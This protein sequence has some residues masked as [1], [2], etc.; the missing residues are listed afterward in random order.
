MGTLIGSE[1]MEKNIT[2]FHAKSF[3]QK[4]VLC[5]LARGDMIAAG[6]D[7]Q[8][9][10][11]ADPQY[12][13]SREGRLCQ[14]LMQAIKDDDFDSF[15]KALSDYNEITPLDSWHM[16]L[17]LKAKRRYFGNPGAENEDDLVGGGATGA[18]G[19]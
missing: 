15:T 9:G 2:K 19:E 18:G 11:N 14:S 8:N 12:P 17:L 6:E 7:H 3:F 13:G 4:A 16:T 1:C 5:G 10:C